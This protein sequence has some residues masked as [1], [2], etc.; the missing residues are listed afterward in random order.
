MTP[1]PIADPVRQSRRPLGALVT[2][3]QAQAV[4]RGLPL[5]VR[6]FV[7]Q[8]VLFAIV[9]NWPFL[10][11]TA[12]QLAPLA[13]HMVRVTD[14]QWEDDVAGTDA[15]IATMAQEAILIAA[16]TPDADPGGADVTLNGW[17]I[18]VL[19]ALISGRSWRV[20]GNSPAD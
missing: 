11:L 20:H 1:D 16:E 2:P 19:L 13:T 8:E 7:A 17:G 5:T 9:G 10:H 15:F 14:A 12:A 3:Q 6:T 18:T 4:W